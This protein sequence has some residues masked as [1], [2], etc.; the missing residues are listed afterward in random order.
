MIFR[1]KTQVYTFV[2]SLSLEIDQ[3]KKTTVRYIKNYFTTILENSLEK[4]KF[5]NLI[6]IFYLST[7]EHLP[8]FLSPSADSKSII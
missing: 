8:I 1:S 2:K 4:K 5:R 7:T 3:F 6:L